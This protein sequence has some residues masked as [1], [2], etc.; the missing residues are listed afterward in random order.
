MGAKN[1]QITNA[2]AKLLMANV[3]KIA[4]KHQV[5]VAIAIVDKKGDLVLLERMDGAVSITSSVA[6]AKATTAIIVN[7][8]ENDLYF[9]KVIKLHKNSIQFL[10]DFSL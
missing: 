6:E 9:Q 1:Q 2:E 10:S 3:K 4:K 5:A 8:L 7:F